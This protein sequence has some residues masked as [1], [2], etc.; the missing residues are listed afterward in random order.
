MIVEFRKGKRNHY[1]FPI[2]LYICKIYIPPFN[3]KKYHKNM[4]TL[5]FRYKYNVYQIFINWN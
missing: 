5:N 1:R 2:G 3:D 4:R